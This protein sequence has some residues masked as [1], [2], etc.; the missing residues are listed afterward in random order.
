MDREPQPSTGSARAHAVTHTPTAVALED[1]LQARRRQRRRRLWRRVALGAVVVLVG[2]GLG[3]VV[4]FSPWLSAQAVQ[5]EGVSKLR[6]GQIK[7]LAQVPLGQPLIRIDT[8]QIASQVE[9]LPAVLTARV[10]RSWPQKITIHVTERTPLATVEYQGR[11]YQVDLDG[12]IFLP[13]AR[14]HSQLPRIRAR[15]QVVD[16]ALAEATSVIAA[17]EQLPGLTLGDIEFIDVASIDQISLQLATQP[18]HTVM[19]GSADQS[20]SKAEILQVLLGQ[21]SDGAAV[22]DVSVPASPTTRPQ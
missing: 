18:A 16:A 19:W 17:L 3:W 8:A 6:P 9:T 5:V 11:W 13:Q 15:A 14:P 1:V 20:E 12:V 7:K 21:L 22:I 10:S 2:A 4:G